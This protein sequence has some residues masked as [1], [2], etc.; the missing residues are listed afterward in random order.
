MTSAPPTPLAPP[1][2]SVPC[3]P[4]WGTGT[5]ANVNAHELT[6]W[7]DMA[8]PTSIWYRLG[9]ALE[10]LR[11]G[12]IRRSGSVRSTASRKKPGRSQ[13]AHSR[14]S[15]SD[16]ITDGITNGLA[17]L[18]DLREAGRGQPRS[19][20]SDTRGRGLDLH[21]LDIDV[22]GFGSLGLGA[23]AALL[24][25]R[26]GGGGS[27]TG[28]RWIRA[29]LAGAG[30]GLAREL[31]RPLLD[32]EPR[33]PD[34]DDELV[35]RVA[36]GAVRGLIYATI[37]DPSIPGPPALRGLLYGSAEYALEPLGGLKGIMGRRAPHRRLPLLGDLLD[38]WEAGDDG[39]VD[40]LAFGLAL[41]L[42]YGRGENDEPLAASSGIG[43]DDR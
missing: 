13:T 30:A 28:P 7:G 23:L 5:R 42:L 41:A 4:L 17:W 31:L 8:D 29:T 15:M 24:L 19:R 39:L 35:E 12:R 21:A 1:G 36:A 32:G 25:E 26:R 20:R 14:T 43:D 34:L 10:E 40:H 18:Q 22:P 3:P 37:V 33:L 2:M 38:A 27:G 16:G 9:F 11:E 6:S